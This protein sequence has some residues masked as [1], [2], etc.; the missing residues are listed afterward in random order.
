[1]LLG[2]DYKLPLFMGAVINLTNQKL[3][4]V[5]SVNYS[6]GRGEK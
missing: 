4:C 2:L 5:V 1:M 3:P 6:A